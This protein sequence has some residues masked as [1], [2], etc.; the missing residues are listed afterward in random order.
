MEWVTKF[1]R[2]RTKTRSPRAPCLLR[3]KNNLLIR[4]QRKHHKKMLQ[5]LPDPA[6]ARAL[7]LLLQPRV[8]PLLLHLL[9]LLHLLRVKTI[10]QPLQKRRM[11]AIWIKQHQ[12]LMLCRK[13]CRKVLMERQVH[14]SQWLTW[15]VSR[16]KKK[17]RN[18]ENC[19]IK[20]S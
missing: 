17:K 14:P 11:M 8:K 16:R 13:K 2:T 15:L 3:S 6:K 18:R 5:S 7:R 20:I 12:N 4:P 10:S 19:P 1:H 9:H